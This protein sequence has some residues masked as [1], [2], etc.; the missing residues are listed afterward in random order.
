LV[1]LRYFGFFSIP[2][3]WVLSKKMKRDYP[4]LGSGKTSLVQRLYGL[5]CDLE[6]RIP[7]PF[8]TAVLALAQLKD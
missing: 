5:L 3:V 2:I 6:G 7:L 4:Q 1:N 8:G